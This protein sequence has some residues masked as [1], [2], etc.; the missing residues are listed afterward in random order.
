VNRV[1]AYSDDRTVEEKVDAA[2][3]KVENIMQ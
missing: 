1:D 3:D 2:L